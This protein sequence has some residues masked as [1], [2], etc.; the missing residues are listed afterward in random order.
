MTDGRNA[1][2][3]RTGREVVVTGYGAVTPLGHN[4]AD[5]WSAM[6]AG[7][8]GVDVLDTIDVTGLGV[9]IG[10]QVRGF[11][12]AR[13][14]PATVSRR[15]DPY[16]QF[17]LAAALEACEHAG[18]VVDESRAPRVAVIIGRPTTSRSSTVS[19]RSSRRSPASTSPT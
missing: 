15:T 14:M 13:Y 2:L 12:P 16:A 5:T 11:T 18:L 17:A 6:L 7:R 3:G 10:G 1:R 8:S 19:P 4:A 9:R